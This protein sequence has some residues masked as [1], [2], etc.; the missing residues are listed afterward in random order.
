MPEKQMFSD[1]FRRHKIEKLTLNELM[2]TLNTLLAGIY[3]FKVS[4]KD[5]RTSLLTSHCSYVSIFDVK[6]VNTG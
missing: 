2:A 1:I 3:L 5:N 6:Q 4:N